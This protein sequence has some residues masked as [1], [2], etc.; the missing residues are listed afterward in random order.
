MMRQTKLSYDEFVHRLIPVRYLDETGLVLYRR[1]AA[2]RSNEERQLA[3]SALLDRLCALGY[4]K[5]VHREHVGG[6]TRSTYRNLVSLDTLVLSAPAPA[7]ESSTGA[8]PNG[9]TTLKAA[10]SL[11]E[12]TATP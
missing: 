9:H 8:Q 4:M 10:P 1:L 7:E 2:S 11:A 3:A 6:E 12:E 5:L